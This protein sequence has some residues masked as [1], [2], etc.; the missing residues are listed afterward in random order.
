MY[1]SR[2]IFFFNEKMAEEVESTTTEEWLSLEEYI[3]KEIKPKQRN[4]TK[5]HC[6]NNILFVGETDSGKTTLLNIL[7]GRKGKNE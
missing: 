5:K 4:E 7:L 3:E 2:S 6:E 1:H